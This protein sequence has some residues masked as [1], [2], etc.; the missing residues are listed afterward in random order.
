VKFDSPANF[1]LRTRRKGY[2]WL[3]IIAKL[4]FIF[5]KI[6]EIAFK[7]KNGIQMPERGRCDL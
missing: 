5:N 7:A 6:I 2:K 4:L 3:E 1:T